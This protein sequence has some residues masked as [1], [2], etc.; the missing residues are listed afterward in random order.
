MTLRAGRRRKGLA[1]LITAL[2]LGFMVPIVG[3]AVDAGVLYAIKARLSAACDA[4]SLAAARS[5]S[6]GLTL[7]EQEASA[8]ARAGAFF[9]ANFP[10][11]MMA[12]TGKQWSVVVTESSFRT[13]TVTVTATVTAPVY[14][15][16][17]LGKTGV[18]VAASGKASRR[19]VNVMLIMDRSGSLQTAGACDDL[20]SAALAFV[21]Q[22]A[23][24]RDRLGLITYGGSSNLD[25]APA[26]EFKTG[27]GNLLTKIDGIF[28]GGCNGWTG[29][30]Q[31]L[32]QGYQQVVA[33]NEPG[34]LNVILFF[35]DGI[36]NA[37]TADFLVKT[38][39]TTFSPTGKSRCWDWQNNKKYNQAG[40]NPVTQVYRG[41]V[42]GQSGVGRGGVRG[43]VAGSIPVSND[44]GAVAIPQ[45]FSGSA[46]AIAD[47]CYFRNNTSDVDDDVPHY[48]NQDFYGNS[49]FGWKSINTYSSGPY[50]G[51]VRI[52]Q[53]SN[54]QNAAINAVDN[55]AQRI[56]NNTLH[57]SIDTVIYSIGLGG[58]G[59][60]EHDLLRRI[61]NDIASP[62]YNANKPLG[63]YV[64][65]PT[66][67][68]LTAAF[69]RIASEILRYA[70]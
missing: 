26:Y 36:P 16:R 7:A 58:A 61:S 28:P 22:F 40:W 69:V 43:H 54:Q 42:A 5:L 56:R 66:S 4:G 2:M 63:L 13:R 59:E 30:S 55:A 19:D 14:F 49:V 47:D 10:D 70:H 64:Y 24:H 9:N 3:L 57:P 11:S 67:A 50:A 35:T 15:M 39:T 20:E 18:T 44:P 34:A 65:A 1:I 52:D 41:F 29:S 45:G 38:Q 60:A 23:N 25:F 37:I 68:E 51:K 21:N 32:W 12:T 46:K 8:A 62:I 53:Q 33:M 48:P 31:G 27:P 6:L 17:I